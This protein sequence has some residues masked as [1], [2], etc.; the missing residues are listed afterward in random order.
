MEYIVKPCHSFLSNARQ[1][2]PAP[3]SINLLCLAFRLIIEWISIVRGVASNQFQP[4]TFILLPFQ[5]LLGDPARSTVPAS[6]LISATPHRSQCGDG[7]WKHM[8]EQRFDEWRNW[9]LSHSNL[10][11][12]FF[13]ANR[14]IT[15]FHYLV[16]PR[17]MCFP[18]CGG[19]V[20]RRNWQKVEI[21]D[22][23]R[24]SDIRVFTTTRNQARTHTP[25]TLTVFPLLKN[26]RM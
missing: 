22:V 12:N 20:D 18:I 7:E 17:A 1:Q 4:R 11:E 5:S 21:S 14:G 24:D 2:S 15:L 10:P 25:L 16:H 6:A 26:R 8:L 3:K 23:L 9:P 19:D 13:V